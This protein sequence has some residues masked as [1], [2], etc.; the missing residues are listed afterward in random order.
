MRCPAVDQLVYDH[1]LPRP[2]ASDPSNFSGILTRFLVFEVR[3]EVHS[4]YG[5]L[6]TQEAKYP[7]LDYCHPIHRIRLGRWPWHRRLFRAFDALRLTPTEIANLTKWEGTRWA[8]ERYE[9]EQNI[10]IQ[11]TAA[12]DMPDYRRVRSWVDEQPQIIDDYVSLF[13]D[14]HTPTAIASGDGTVEECLVTQVPATSRLAQNAAPLQESNGATADHTAGPIAGHS[15][16]ET[17][18]DDEF[19][20]LLSSEEG[21]IR[22]IG[23]QL[24]ERLR[25]RVAAHNAGDT[26]Q[27]LDE[28]W[29][30]WY[31]AAIETGDL[32]MLAQHMSL[33]DLPFVHSRYTSQ[34]RSGANARR[35]PALPAS[36]QVTDIGAEPISGQSQS[37]NDRV[38]SNIVPSQILHSARQGHWHEVPG[39][40][41]EVMRQTIESGTYQEAAASPSDTPFSANS[42]TMPAAA[43]FSPLRF[44]NRR[45]H[46]SNASRYQAIPSINLSH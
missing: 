12:D 31:K 43:N 5:H 6:D 41:H 45:Q 8:K 25:E 35:D 14:S 19:S 7:G 11:D 13:V 21:E 29:E 46:A 36:D 26:S 1:M 33:D 15:D 34:A 30:Q 28:D 27:P 24:N 38:F 20:R 42:A 16:H 2:K 40:L 39:F 4:F 10:V 23:T 9:K 17:T 3:Q 44:R 37:E 18:N 22:S 32:D